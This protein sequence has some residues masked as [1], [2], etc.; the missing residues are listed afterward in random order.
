MKP[1][2][3]THPA[4]PAGRPVEVGRRFLLVPGEA[5]ICGNPAQTGSRMPIRLSRGKAFGSGLHETTVSCIEALERLDSLENMSVLD[6]GTGTG[7]LSIAA[8]F[9]GA[10]N[11]V[12]FDIDGDAV[13]TCHRNASLNQV[14]ERLTIFRGN[15]DALSTAARFDVILANIHG[16]IIINWAHRMASAVRE[17]GNLILSGLDYTDSR[18]VKVAMNEHR[19]EE[20]SV[21]FLEEFVTQVW[22]RPGLNQKG[23]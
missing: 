1:T 19:L 16:D 6:M 22:R 4:F 21:S 18:P 15:L 10:R 13:R 3:I 23:L 20:I 14:H 17:G 9:L 5:P 11:A 12:A 2:S 7:I 8:I